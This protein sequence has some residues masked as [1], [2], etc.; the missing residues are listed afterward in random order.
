MDYY[1]WTIPRLST[2]DYH[3]TFDATATVVRL[4]VA[5]LAAAENQKNYQTL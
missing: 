1:A 5:P 3:A 2:V 4:Y